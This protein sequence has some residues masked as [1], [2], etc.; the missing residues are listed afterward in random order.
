[1]Q[2]RKYGYHLQFI[3]L[4]ILSFWSVQV[5][6]ALIPAEAPGL[7]EMLQQGE[8]ALEVWNI[9]EAKRWAE[10]IKSKD[11]SL[12]EAA[13]FHSRV[14]FYQGEYGKAIEAI[15]Q[16]LTKDPNNEMYQGYK[17]FFEN[18]RLATQDLQEFSSDHFTLLVEQK[19]D[20]ILVPYALEAL[21]KAYQ[22]FGEQFHFTP[23]ERI[24][25]EIFPDA[26]SFYYASSLSRR[27][28]E[29]SGAIGICKFNKIMLLSPRTLLR[30]YRW[31]DALT[32]EYMHYVIVRLSNNKAPIW[33]HEGVAKYQEYFWRSPVSLYLS[34]VNET[35]LANALRENDFVSFAQMDPSLVKLD[36]THQV[37]LAYAEAASAIDF[38]LH[39]VGYEG[40]NRIFRFMAQSEERGAQEAIRQE[41]Q[42]DF[43]AFEAAWKEFLWTQNLREIE[44]VYLEKYTL[45]ETVKD[46]E[47]WSLREIESQVVRNHVRLG[48]MLRSRGRLSAAVSEYMRALR[49]SSPSPFLYNK[50]GKTLLLSNKYEEARVYLEQAKTLYPDY[51]TTYNNLGDLFLHQKQLSEAEQAYT[52]AVQINPFDPHGHQGLRSVYLLRGEKEKAA[53]IQKILLTLMTQ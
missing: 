22:I 18:T 44:G 39:K 28:I 11:I 16:A 30:G 12:P 13:F 27:D 24:R 34:P 46:E 47:Q 32:H 23:Q 14:W 51:V 9:P 6:S 3:A 25:V 10:Q 50:L 20:G 31:L 17:G 41:L 26:E 52:E 21:E 5:Q 38:I 19:R 45:K 29:V 36:T 40:L 43:P 15:E 49:K 35:L 7:E 48:D 42:V 33:V 2:K 4:L 1:M 53:K 37:R 8:M